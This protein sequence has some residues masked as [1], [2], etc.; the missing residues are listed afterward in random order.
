MRRV[1]TLSPSKN[2]V[3][4][5]SNSKHTKAVGTIYCKSLWGC[6]VC[7]P[8]KM[9]KK[10]AIIACG[11]EALKTQ[12]QVPIH[13]T[14][15]VP[16]HTK[17]FT[18][19]QVSEILKKTWQTFIK[20]GMI[21]NKKNS[22]KRSTNSKQKDIYKLSNPINK[23]RSTFNSKFYVRVY[24]YTWG[25]NGWH[26]H[27]HS[28]FWVDKNKLNKV[29]D[30]EKELLIR[31]RELAFKFTCSITKKYI[32]DPKKFEDFKESLTYA[33]EADDFKNM[34]RYNMG[35]H[36]SQENG[37]VRAQDSSIYICGWGADKEVTGNIQRKASKSGHYTPYQMLLEA[38]KYDKDSDEFKT[39]MNRYL[40]FF[41]AAKTFLARRVNFGCATEFM[42][43]I[44]NW[45]TTNDYIQ[46]FKK[47][48]QDAMDQKTK[49][50]AVYWFSQLQWNLLVQKKLLPYIMT[51]AILPN[52]K[53]IIDTVLEQYDIKRTESIPHSDYLSKVLSQLN[54]YIDIETDAETAND[55]SDELIA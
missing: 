11:I 20:D 5:L 2:G 25:Q 16:H 1:V 48:L 14:F 43:I 12:G 41:V 26:P 51:V 15:T 53:L 10:A 45:K 55:D 38:A 6:P 47:K 13:I 49:W 29:L 17:Y 50:Y 21:T 36:I 32:K 24:E 52:A 40:E 22:R 54:R 44:N 18:C 19:D 39:W 8:Y 37:V 33:Y 4:L 30:F 42:K 27:I 46:V 3:Y 35:L 28:L 31:W 7:E 34:I 23:F 9:S